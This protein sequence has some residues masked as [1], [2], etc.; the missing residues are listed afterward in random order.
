MRR[1]GSSTASFPLTAVMALLV[2]ATGCGSSDPDTGDAIA[3]SSEEVAEP[4]DRLTLRVVATSPHD[5]DAFTQGLELVD[6]RL[7]ETTGGYGESEIREIDRSTGRVLRSASLDASWF[8]EGM[9]AIGGD[10]AVQLTWKAGR[11][12]VWD[13]AT[14]TVVDVWTYG[15]QGWGLCLLEAGTLAMSDGSSFLTLRDSGDLTRIADVQVLLDGRPVERLNELECVDGTVWANI[16]LTDTIVAIDP[17]AGRVTAVVDASGLL[18]DRSNLG[19]DD[20]LNG[21]A[22]DPLSGHFLLTGKRWPVLFEVAL[23]SASDQLSD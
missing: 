19:V 17:T 22:Y 5:P 11:A 13:L 15:G 20:V 6:G 4:A 7:L 1:R 23:E 2:M 8:G 18:A 16:W 21:I 3:P 12:L 10:R 9:T 14:L